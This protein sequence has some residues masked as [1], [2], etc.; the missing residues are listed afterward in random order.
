VIY[1]PWV[2]PIIIAGVSGAIWAA[3]AYSP[4]NAWDLAIVSCIMGI[5]ALVVWLGG[6]ME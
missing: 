3:F 5:M 4:G 6:Q 2:P 1:L